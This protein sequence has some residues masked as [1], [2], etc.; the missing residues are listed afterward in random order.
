MFPPQFFWTMIVATQV[1]VEDDDETDWATQTT[2]D[3]FVKPN[4]IWVKEKFDEIR[5]TTGCVMFLS[6]AQPEFQRPKPFYYI[7]GT[8]EG[9]LRCQF[10]IQQLMC[11]YTAQKCIDFDERYD[12]NK[13][14]YFAVQTILVPNE[15]DI[16]YFLSPLPHSLDKKEAI[17]LLDD[18][19]VEGTKV[20]ITC[21]PQMP[22]EG[23]CPCLLASYR[24]RTGRTWCQ[25][26]QI[27]GPEPSKVEASRQ[28]ILA[29]LFSGL[30]WRGQ[31][32]SS[33][34]K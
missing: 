28:I 26:I 23:P 9:V 22:G 27:I 31:L 15:I 33:I 21:P 25:Y 6:E 5:R 2:R 11:E 8:W 20:E 16:C 18:L 12:I 32:R 17:V 7:Q 19:C 14:C 29:R 10:M 34:L 13:A 24:E 3:H 4:P 30:M 1:F